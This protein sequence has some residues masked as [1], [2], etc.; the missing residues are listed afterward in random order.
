M[1]PPPPPT[2]RPTQSKSPRSDFK[3]TSGIVSGPQKVVEYGPGGV[4]KSELAAAIANIG[5]KPLFVDIGKGSRFIDV[6]RIDSIETW[7]DLRDFLHSD[8]VDPFGAI[9]IDDLTKA[10][11]MATDWVVR[12]VAHEK[13][14]PISCIQ[15]YG[16]GNG[17]GHVFD[18]MLLLL[19]DLDAIH[20]K[21]KWIICIAHECTSEFP[22]PNGEDY[23]R[24]EPR[25]QSPGSG[26]NS[27]RLRVKE[28][29]DHLLFVG[30][31]VFSKDGKAQGSGTRTIYPLE[32]GM[33]LAKTRTLTGTI[34]YERHSEELWKQLTGAQS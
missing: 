33:C 7:E 1:P 12:N 23:I 19:Q 14:K 3:I 24:F 2:G 11:E 31:D 30:Y 26:K 20:R 5:V 27:V 8:A 17:Y 22:N 13:G 15:D 28:W 16:W 34:N 25:L 4:G 18:Q 32:T 6:P 10:E 9:V 21:G 29:A